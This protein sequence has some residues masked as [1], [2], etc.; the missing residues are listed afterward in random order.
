M[1]TIIAGIEDGVI[2]LDPAENLVL[3]NLA[4]REI[5]GLKEADVTGRP[6]EV[7]L[8]SSDL[9]ASLA[10]PSNRATRLFEL[11]FEDGRVFKA[12]HTP[13]PQIGSAVTLHDITEIKRLEKLKGDFV[14]TVAHDLRS[15]LTAVLGYAEL[16]EHAGALNENQH[17]FVNRI[18]TSVK[19]ITG[20]VNE[21]LEFGRLESTADT[22]RENVQL[23]GIMKDSLSLFEALILQKKLQM[24]LETATDLPPVRANPVRM[25]QLM[26]NLISNAIKYTPEGGEVQLRLRCDNHQLVFQVKNSGPGIPQEDQAHIFERFYRARNVDGTQGTGLGLTI[27]KSI[28]DS[29]NGRVWVES[30][31]GVGSTFFVVLPA[32]ET[33]SA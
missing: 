28:A 1:E 18:Q 13:I 26:D 25:R 14:H 15:P 5:F 23:E 11:N 31:E 27:V 2:V 19:S 32:Q 12:Q 4:A 30:A 17:D 22:R 8:S 3:I 10:S 20:L 7:V 29:Y 9:P 16:V 6:L 33:S 21:L 24:K